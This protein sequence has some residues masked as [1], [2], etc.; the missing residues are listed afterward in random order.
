MGAASN[1]LESGLLNHVLRGST[2]SKPSTVAVALTTD[3][4]VDTQTGV[5]I[6][7]VANSNAYARVDLGAPA[8]AD[9]D[10]MD[11]VNGSG[12]L[13][14]TA[15]VSFTTA[16]GDWGMV[17]GVCLI[18]NAT[19]GAGNLLFHAALSTAR[20]VKSGDTFEFAIGALDVYLD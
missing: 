17:S 16:T 13:E 12:H 14:N 20:D 15:A 7:E 2:Y 8:D 6:N 9:W 18:D 5:T 10:F 3:I 11:Q 1:Y 19:H 4:P